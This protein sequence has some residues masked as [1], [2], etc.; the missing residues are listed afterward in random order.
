MATIDGKHPYLAATLLALLRLIHHL[1]LSCKLAAKTL[2][3]CGE[4][5]DLTNNTCNFAVI[6]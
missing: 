3:K 2:T 5:A 6:N 4:M 1:F